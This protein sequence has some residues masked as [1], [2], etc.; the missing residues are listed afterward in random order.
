M[1]SRFSAQ[2]ALTLAT[3]FAI[4]CSDSA[5]D[6]RSA[7]PS[8]E[9]VDPTE[10]TLQF[11]SHVY[12]SFAVAASTGGGVILKG[13]AN[14][15][16][17]PASGPGTCVQ[18]L[19]YN[20]QEKPTSG[21]LEK[22]HPHCFNPVTTIEVVLEPITSCYTGVQEVATQPP[23]EEVPKEAETAP[24]AAEETKSPCPKPGG[25][26]GA[27]HTVLS[28]SA[29]GILNPLFVEAVDF[30]EPLVDDKTRGRGVVIGY[31]MDAAT[32]Q[33]VG[34]LRFDLGQYS[35]SIAHLHLLGQAG[36][37]IGD[38][39]ESPCLDKVITAVYNPLKPELGGIGPV[40]AAVEGFLWVTPASSPYNYTGK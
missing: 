32:K 29:S 6:P 2:I 33:R 36:C 11:N 17:K 10:R 19:W 4:G 34:T 22:P 31:A 25:V 9:L 39:I 14:F 7:D 37:D 3:V 27:E 26:P 15:P 21:S 40:D 28:L 23:A 24:P 12:G 8:F 1:H 18:G 35:G 13:P 5:T 38:Q 20:A 16:G 30:K